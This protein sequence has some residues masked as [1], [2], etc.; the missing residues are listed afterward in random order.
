M[1]GD[2]AVYRGDYKL[3]RHMPPLGDR[4]WHL[5]NIANDLTE[6]KNLKSANPQKFQALL[7]TWEE[8]ESQMVDA[9]F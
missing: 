4:S 6:S 8:Y 9:A 1:C 5:Y 7:Q 3:V 2:V